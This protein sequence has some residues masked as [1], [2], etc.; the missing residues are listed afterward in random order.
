MYQSGAVTIFVLLNVD[1]PQDDEFQLKDE[2][3][4]VVKGSSQVFPA[5]V[6]K[7][8]IYLVVTIKPGLVLMWDKKTSLFIKLSPEYKVNNLLVLFDIQPNL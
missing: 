7:M 8:G 5:Q 2:N 6:H 3:F 4:L 1:L